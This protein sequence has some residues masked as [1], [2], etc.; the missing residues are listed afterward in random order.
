MAID[1]YTSSRVEE[2]LDISLGRYS[3]DSYRPG[4]D[5]Y[6][7][8]TKRPVSDFA[9][10]KEEPEENAKRTWEAC[11]AVD[12]RLASEGVE[13]KRRLVSLFEANEVARRVA[14]HS[15]GVKKGLVVNGGLVN[16][17]VKRDLVSEWICKSVPRCSWL[18]LNGG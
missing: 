1:K 8:I 4:Q 13:R 6:W 2:P 12:A 11:V 14:G 17:D 5:E 18:A 10:K 7:G 15:G 3:W 9:P 16:A